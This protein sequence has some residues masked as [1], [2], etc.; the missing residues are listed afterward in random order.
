[1]IFASSTRSH[2][3]PMPGRRHVV[4]HRLANLPARP[5]VMHLQHVTPAL[6]ALAAFPD[7]P[8]VFT[9]HSATI[10]V[11]A[12]RPHPQIRRF[13]A[14]DDFC[15]ARAVQRNIPPDRL[16]VVLNAVDLTRFRPRPPLPARPK[17]ALMLTKTWEQQD[18]VRA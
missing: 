15:R 8:A 16:S 18:V 7:V 11:E 12:P 4:V 13:A 17:A 2:A 5:D 14:V 10:E 3:G 6:M 9:T 1:M